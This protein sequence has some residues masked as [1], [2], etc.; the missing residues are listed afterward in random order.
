MV[1]TALENNLELAYKSLFS[2]TKKSAT[3]PWSYSPEIV[4]YSCKPEDKKHQ[5]APSSNKLLQTWWIKTTQ[6]Y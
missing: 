5:N 3:Q 6:V 4:L 2:K 1:Q